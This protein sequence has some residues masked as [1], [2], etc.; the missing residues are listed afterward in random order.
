MWHVPLPV[1]DQIAEELRARIAELAGWT[2]VRADTEVALNVPKLAVIAQLEERKEP[3]DTTAYACRLD[4]LVIVRVRAEDA[5][6][7]H[8]SNAWRYL[9]ECV[10]LIEAKV[11]KIDANGWPVPWVSADEITIQGHEQ[12]P[13]DSND[14][15]ALLRLQ[16]QYRHLYGDPATGGG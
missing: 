11:H 4:L 14:V 16:A 3:R 8:G 12:V 15:V 5:T 13:G 2:V 9:D 1:R 6:A 7:T 10:G